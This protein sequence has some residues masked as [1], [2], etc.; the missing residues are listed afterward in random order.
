MLVITLTKK[1]TMMKYL[2]TLTLAVL[3]FQLSAQD[4]IAFEQQ[5]W[6][7]I[8]EKAQSEDKLIFLD[9]YAEW[10]GPCK[11]MSKNVFTDEQVANF[12]NDKF[13]N[14]KIDMEKGEGVELARKYKVQA[15]PTLLYIDGEG[16]IAH[17]AIGYRGAEQLI[18]LGKTA[19]DPDKRI[20][21][22]Q[23]EYE[24][25]NRDPEFLAKYAKA[26][27]QAGLSNA[28]EITQ[29][30]LETQEDWSDPETMRL[31]LESVQKAEGKYYDYVIENL[32]TYQTAF[33]KSP[34][35]S[36]INRL[37]MQSLDPSMEEEALMAKAEKKFNEAFPEMAEQSMAKFKMDYY[38]GTQQL[39][40][41]AEAAVAYF[42][43]YESDNHSELNNVAWS[44]YENIEDE[45]MLREALAWAKKSVELRDAYFNND[46]L[47][48]LYY[49]LGK[50]DK[51]KAA[52]QHAIELAKASGE[53]F[54]GTE[55]LLEK[56]EQL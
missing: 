34:V 51:A 35:N 15:Y 28:K 1:D 48:A 16:S 8:L 47:A 54:S 40:K 14:A 45:E 52:A 33:G 5:K 23:E 56:I 55:E 24:S 49:K 12:Y 18:A 3:S 41:Y 4:A 9:A 27:S 43:A 13:I 20:S 53:D 37:I 32:A 6:Q 38:S 39:D 44:F 17:R 29:A 26:A 42:D 11:M 50:K 30:Y 46:T 22:L 10:C 25:G 7:A 36:F 19:L 31:V 21:S 2:L